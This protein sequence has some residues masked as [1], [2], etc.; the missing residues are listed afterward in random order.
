[1]SLIYI[2]TYMT[3]INFHNPKRSEYTFASSNLH[4]FQQQMGKQNIMNQNAA[5]I[6]QI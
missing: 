1:M 5:I 6:P 3:E 2:L 4:I